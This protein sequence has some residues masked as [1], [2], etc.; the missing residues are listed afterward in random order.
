MDRPAEPMMSVQ[1]DAEHGGRWPSLRGRNGRE[2]LWRR[3]APQRHSVRPGQAFVDAG[4]MEECLPTIAGDPDHGDVWSRPWSRDG[5]GLSV[6]V[7]GRRLHRTTTV[8]ADGVR[9]SYEL[10][11]EPGW[12][13]IWAAHTLIDVSTR[14]RV[15]APAGRKIWVNSDEGTADRHWPWHGETDLAELGE[16]DGTAL[17]ILI[18]ELPEITVVDGAD[19]ITFRLEVAGQPSGFAIWRNLRGWP[20]GAPYRNIGIEPML[21]YSPTL[22]LAREGEAAVVPPGGRVAWSLTIDA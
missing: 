21:G 19:R 12:W 13:F 6:E 7:D 11:A 3:D 2:W 1:V 18:P 10:T 4:G 14:A 8:G 15:L 16:D 22:A 20:P 17:M 5:D 9:S